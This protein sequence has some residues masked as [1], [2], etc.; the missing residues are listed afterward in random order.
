MRFFKGGYQILDLAGVSD[1]ASVVNGAY[2]KVLS[3]KPVV[4]KNLYGIVGPT[5]MSVLL[6]ETAGGPAQLF[7]TVTAEK[8][9]ALISITITNKDS[10]TAE[11]VTLA[12]PETAG[13]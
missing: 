2:S 5:Y 8:A 12:V 3:G 6:P 4:V 1:T 9:P 13:E 10:V 7:C 11:N